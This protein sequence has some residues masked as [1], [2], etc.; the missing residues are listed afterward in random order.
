[1]SLIRKKPPVRSGILRAPKREF[2]RH[3]A[4]IRRHACSVPGC[5]NRTIE[6][7]HVRTGTDG[8]T[9]LKPHDRWTLPLCG[10]GFVNGEAVEGHHREQHRLGEA[11]FEKKYGIDMKEIAKEFAKRSPD[12]N[13]KEAM[14]AE[15]NNG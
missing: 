11:S 6:C 3:R 10:P 7:A 14:M 15:R 1:M 13:M 8:G 5:E 2:P 4:F 12:Q 9:S